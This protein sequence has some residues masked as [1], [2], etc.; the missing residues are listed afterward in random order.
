V[1]GFAAWLRHERNIESSEVLDAD[2]KEAL[3][4]LDDPGWHLDE[5][6]ADRVR[7]VLLTAAAWYFLRAKTP[8]GLPLNPVAR[9]HLGNG[10]RL[11]R[12]DFLGDFSENGLRQSFGLMVNYLYALNEIESNHEAYAEK[13]TVAA[14]S[15]IRKLARAAPAGVS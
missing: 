9:F 14:S 4:L 11:E 15:A 5:E 2:A 3:R 13:G 1:P 10:A 12:L 7:P 6:K 8:G